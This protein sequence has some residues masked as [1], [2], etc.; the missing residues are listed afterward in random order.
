MDKRIVGVVGAISGLAALDPAQ[1]AVIGNPSTMGL[2]AAT[3]FADLLDPIPN[4]LALLQTVEAT[5]A[6][7][8]ESGA[9]DDAQV[10]LVGMR[11]HHHH[12][13]RM[14]HH[15]HHHRS[16]RHHH[17]HHHHRMR[18]HHHHHDHHRSSY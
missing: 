17:H 18:Q 16:V 10:T 13:H 3:S 9:A 4:A 12:H 15:H 11:H 6:A 7:L 14:R 1:A 8:A 5:E 2:P